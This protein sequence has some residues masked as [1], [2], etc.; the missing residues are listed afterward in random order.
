MSAWASKV[1]PSM[2]NKKT[3]AYAKKDTLSCCVSNALV[4]PQPSL[5]LPVSASQPTDKQHTPSSSQDVAGDSPSS[6]EDES[7]S[8]SLLIRITNLITSGLPWTV[9][10][11][12]RVRLPFQL[13]SFWLKV[14]GWWWMLPLVMFSVQIMQP[15]NSSHVLNI[16]IG[17]LGVLLLFNS[18]AYAAGPPPS[19]PRLLQFSCHL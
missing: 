12:L 8:Y 13:N 16:L 5:F 2:T 3:K 15:K 17:M 14:L 9:S 10:L 11:I 18:P 1:F 7:P 19:N 6:E 4:S